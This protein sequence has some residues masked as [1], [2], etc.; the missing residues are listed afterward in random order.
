MPGERII[1]QRR[2]IGLL[3]FFAT[4]PALLASQAAFAVDPALVLMAFVVIGLLLLLAQP[5]RTVG[6]GLLVASAT[7]YG[8]LLVFA[9]VFASAD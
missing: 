9:V 1:G 6:I 5:L 3:A 8:A 2:V 7:M 4:F